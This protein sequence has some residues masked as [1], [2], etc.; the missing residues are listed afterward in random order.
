MKQASLENSKH[1][2][3]YGGEVNTSAFA[4]NLGICDRVFVHLQRY[5][6]A[7]LFVIAEQIFPK[8]KPALV[9]HFIE[10]KILMILLFILFS[11]ISI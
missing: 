11:I 2:H 8:A 4:S 6:Q 9:S 1:D 7:V 3:T 10:Y 5:Q